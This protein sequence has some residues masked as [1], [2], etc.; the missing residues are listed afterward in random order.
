MQ[1]RKS[2]AMFSLMALVMITTFLA[3]S[4]K[5]ESKV[6]FIFKPAPNKTVAAKIM[7]KDLTYDELLKGAEADIYEAKL[8]VYQIKMDR[9]KALVIKKVMEADPSYKG[10]NEAYLA[11]KIAGKIKVTDKQIMAFAKER[12]IPE[13]NL[14]AQFKDRIKEFLTREQK[15][16]AVDAWLAGK[17]K[18]NPVEVYLE[19][20]QRPVADV[21]VGNAATFGNANA[22]VTIV[23]FSDF[24]CPFCS[25]AADI[26]SQIKKKYGK[27][28]RVAFKNYPLPFHSHAKV[29]AQAGLCANEQSP[30]M[31]WKM[32]D[33]MFAD[34]AKLMES[35][36]L[37]SAK[38][39]GL[40]EKKFSECLKSGKFTAQI[41]AEIK[42]GQDIGV[43]STPTFFVNGMLVNGAQPI[44]V[45]SEIIDDE[46]A[47]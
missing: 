43:K 46:L 14:N 39:I 24:Q 31:F 41:D 19:K 47:K 20:P 4:E 2:F 40:N 30:K 26:V 6:N 33:A 5:A 11:Q 1:K 29:A 9:L 12:N 8:K 36:L 27:K 28:V 17:T 13:A 32:H 38:K 44:K 7:G 22:K 15:G 35:G 37:D 45:F 10:D 21:K 18:R 25:K 23:E 34:Q 16:K 42:E 3:C